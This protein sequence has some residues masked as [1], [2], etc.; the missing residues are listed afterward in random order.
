MQQ[1]M[2]IAG[3][4]VWGIGLFYCIIFFLKRHQ[5][6]GVVMLTRRYAVL[7]A[8][9]LTVTLFADVSKLHLLWWGPL[10][11]PLNLMLLNLQRCEPS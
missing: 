3:W 4:I 11:Y 2:I 6:G 5:D 1:I 10:A 9:G 7:L 8:I